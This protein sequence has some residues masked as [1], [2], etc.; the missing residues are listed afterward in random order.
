MS[1]VRVLWSSKVIAQPRAKDTLGPCAIIPCRE[2]GHEDDGTVTVS[3]E[4]LSPF[5]GS[6][7]L[8][9][10]I[11]LKASDTDGALLVL[12]AKP[13]GNSEIRDGCGQGLQCTMLFVVESR[14]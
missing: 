9:T 12:P 2:S 8:S 6:A 7:E 10:M 4:G 13:F 3:V 5:H 14:T 11:S 1:C